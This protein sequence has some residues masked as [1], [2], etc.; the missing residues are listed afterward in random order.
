[1]SETLKQALPRLSHGDH[2]CLF[3]NSPEEQGRVTSPFLA[4]GLERGERC[5]FVG[6]ESAVE[7]VREGLRSEGVNVDSQERRNRLALTSSRDYL[8]RGHWRTEKMLGFLQH[9]Y[10]D[11]LAEDCTALRAAGDVS[12]Q[13]GPHREYR[14]IVYYEALLDL[15]FIGKRMVGMCQY[16]KDDCPPE[17]LRAILNTHKIA[18]IDSNICAN[19]HYVPPELLIE[20]DADARER[21]RVE[22][23]TSQLLRVKRAEEERDAAQRQ[24]L[25]AQKL[26]AVGRLASSVAHDFN[27][28]LTVILGQSD[29]IMS[30]PGASEPVKTCAGEIRLCG[31]RAAAL[32]RK[33]LAFSRRAPSQ[34]RLVN[35]NEVVSG[36][37]TFLDR[38]IGENVE[39][40]TELNPTLGA[41][42]ADPGEIEQVVM[43]LIVNAR[44]A[45]PEGGRILLETLDAAPDENLARAHPEAPPGPFVMLAVSDC[46]QGMD[47]ATR[48][49][50]FE[51]FFTTK[52]AGKGTGLGLSTVREI[53]QRCGGSICVQS[54]PGKGSSFKVY[55]PRSAAGPAARSPRPSVR[56]NAGGGETVLVVDDDDA[57]RKLVRR[58]LAECGYA[59]LDAAA[60]GQ[61]TAL[62]DGHAGPI[63][64]LIAD[65]VL[66]QTSGREL[67]RDVR[68]RRPDIKVL[69][70]EKPFTADALAGKVRE[71]LGR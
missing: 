9:A 33:L 1:M 26:E 46:G 19:F 67:A 20:K 34:T 50:I 68:Q 47:A 16:R 7:A 17:T 48:E 28:I 60:P 51:P 55:L 40:A 24:L 39:L 8:D 4:I 49:R 58:I 52:A 21:M 64:L 31:E 25:Q 2:C 65:S 61:A 6:G 29:S 12:W 43:N 62:C 53:V 30:D 10:D 27:N 3:F 42:E 13:V 15:F 56:E 11:A 22:W 35:L 14:E 44:D 54:E 18:A 66:P 5:L 41:V 37:K 70:L 45:M 71:A 69:F 36:M 23:M 38:L 57:V 32:T 59:V 63:H